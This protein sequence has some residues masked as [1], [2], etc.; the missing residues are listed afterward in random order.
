MRQ[1]FAGGVVDGE[2]RDREFR[3]ERLRALARQLLQHSSASPRRWSA[4]D[5]R[6]AARAATA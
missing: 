4:M 3:S 2:D 1:H 5:L 6:A